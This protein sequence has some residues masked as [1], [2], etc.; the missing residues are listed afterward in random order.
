MSIES[1]KLKDAK[2]GSASQMKSSIGLPSVFPREMGPNAMKYLQEVV[3]SGLTSDIVSRFERILADAHGR[4][5]CMMTPGCTN[6]LFALFN[7]LDFEPGDEIIVSP[8]ADYGD[9]CGLLFENYIP[10][11]CDTD[12]DTGLITAE[13]IAPC[14]TERT[15]AILAVNFFGLTCDFDPIMELA[16]KHNLLV[17]EDVCQSILA[18]YKGRLAGTLADIAVFSFDSEKVLGGDMGGAVMTDDEDLYYRLVNRALSRGAKDFPGFGRKHL[19]RGVAL[20]APQCTAATTMANWE[21][22][23]RQVERRRKTARLLTQRLETIEGIIP[24]RVPDGQ[25]HS[26]WMYGFRVDPA[27]FSVSPAELAAKLN[28]A[29]IPCGQGKYYVLPASVPFLAEYVEKGVYP[30]NVPVASRKIDYDPLRVC[31]NATAFMDTYIRWLWTEKYTEQDVEL[32]ASIIREVC[33]RLLINKSS[34]RSESNER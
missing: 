25:E 34:E 6:A 17:I 31:P 20:R 11:F 29:G 33:E 14:I 5:Y 15:R 21:I 1:K 24:Y 16:R 27:Q 22:L 9:I 30:F 23:P 4:K 7:A 26:Y 2:Y 3:D 10:V 32:M 12:P 8:I 13:T 28:E 18:T 19:Y